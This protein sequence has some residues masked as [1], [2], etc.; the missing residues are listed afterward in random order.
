MAKKRV[1][2]KKQ[3]EEFRKDCMGLALEALDKG[4][5][6]TAKK[7]CRQQDEDKHIIHDLYMVWITAL[8]SWI[9]EHSGEEEAVRAVRETIKNFIL[10]LVKEKEDLVAEKGLGAWVER[11][12][13]IWRQHSMYPGFT[14]DEDD[15]KFIL[16]MKPCGSGG[17]LIDM[18]VYDG[19]LGFAKLENPGF[20]TW[21]EKDIPI[22]CSHCPWGH[23]ILPISE[24]GK[25]FWIHAQRA[26][27]QGDPCIL[28]IYKDPEKIPEKYYKRIGLR[29]PQKAASS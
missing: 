29:K 22:Y 12:V 27:K 3:L 24:T 2:T 11:I 10:P 14:V 4:D 9:H 28:H 1:F 23:E 18:G 25:P 19:P 5:I 20:H 26:K 21:G 8:L 17:R 13:Q 7:W 16:T 15:E 6:E